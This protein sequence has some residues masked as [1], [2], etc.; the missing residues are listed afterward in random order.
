M[1]QYIVKT[2]FEAYKIIESTTGSKA[3]IDFISGEM[4]NEVLLAQSLGGVFYDKHQQ[5]NRVIALTW[6][7]CSLLYANVSHD[8]I[9]LDS[10]EISPEW[11]KDRYTTG[12]QRFNWLLQQQHRSRLR[13]LSNIKARLG[14]FWLSCGLTIGSYSRNGYF[15][16]EGFYKQ[17]GRYWRIATNRLGKTQPVFD[18]GRPLVQDNYISLFDRH[19]RH[20]PKRNVPQWQVHLFHRWA[21]QLG[22]K[23]VIISDL[24][25]RKLPEGVIRI[26]SP[27]RDMTAIANI[28]QNSLLHGAPASGAGELAFVFGCNYVQLGDSS[29]TISHLYN[30]LIFAPVLRARG[31]KHFG[32]F[33]PENTW[34]RRLGKFNPHN[35][36]IEA[37][38]F[39]Y[40]KTCLT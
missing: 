23:L 16:K 7:G 37:A 40:L 31:Y 14:P 17:Y 26:Q 15:I 10:D 38:C 11:N 20:D 36:E 3:I 6:Q 12:E 19:E 24:Y 21:T 29:L 1:T 35:L 5:Q 22:I 25:P 28:V 27:H 32:I 8:Q 39:D 13:A 2:L 34:R 18:S 33:N 9:E 30:P 4:G